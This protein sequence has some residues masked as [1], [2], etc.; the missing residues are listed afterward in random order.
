M[1]AGLQ[2]GAQNG[3]AL[4]G[5]LQADALQMLKK[6]LLR[7]TH[8]FARGRGMIVNT[9]L[10]HLS[11]GIRAKPANENE[12]HFQL[13]AVPANSQ[14]ESSLDSSMELC[15]SLTIHPKW[16]GPDLQSAEG[17]SSWR[18]AASLF[19]NGRIVWLISLGS[20]LIRHR[21]RKQLQGCAHAQALGPK[22]L[23]AILESLSSGFHESHSP[24]AA[25]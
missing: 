21:T 8:G 15:A 25:G 12:I 19:R 11:S 24:W 1:V 4:L 20:L 18:S 16:S 9:S 5:V 10:Q 23:T 14:P 13:Y 2:E 17:S 6:D 22:L 7:L 3:I